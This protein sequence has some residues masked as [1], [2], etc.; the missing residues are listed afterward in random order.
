MLTCSKTDEH[1]EEEW[2]T[3]F[4]NSSRYL[5]KKEALEHLNILTWN[6]KIATVFRK[7]IN[8]NNRKI[9]LYAITNVDS[10]LASADSMVIGEELLNTAYD[11]KINSAV[12]VKAISKASVL[13]LNGKVSTMLNTLCN[14]SSYN[15]IAACIEGIAKNDA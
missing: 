14:D 12:R 9:R 7:A 6:D 2:I 1:T 11:T 10:L 13:S 15:V 4:N 5:D 3:L 8:D